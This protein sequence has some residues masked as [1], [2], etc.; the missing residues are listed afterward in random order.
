MLIEKGRCSSWLN[1]AQRLLILLILSFITL[2][3]FMMIHENNFNQLTQAVY[4]VIEGKPHWLAYQ[5]RLLGPY[6][7]LAISKVGFSFY[8]SLKI[9]YWITITAEI[10]LL[11]FVL[12]P[13]TATEK[14]A[15][16]LVALY[17]LAFTLYQ[18]SWYY[19][20]DSMDVIIFTLFSYL[21][22]KNSKTISMV[23]LFLISLLNRES[24]L[25]IAFYFIVQGLDVKFE[26]KNLKINIIS[27]KR[28]VLGL[29]MMIFGIIE[30][31]FVRTLLFISKPNGLYDLK[32]KTLGNF[33]NLPQNFVNFDIR[34]WFF[35]YGSLSVLF[36]I[37]K[38]FNKNQN[39]LFLT[40]I[41]MM[42]GI[43]VFGLIDETRLYLML[44]PIFIF[45]SINFQSNKFHVELGLRT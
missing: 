24:A 35:I 42:I 30:I 44:F 45:L 1:Q 41:A 3:F 33:I 23:T 12:R 15:Y 31:K 4:G 13:F 10:L 26:K 14:A 32:H 36:M 29:G 25:F 43:L 11:F 38:S 21:V 2:Y 7:V 20:W 39:D 22:L 6:M 37:Y 9:Y 5:N 18:H 40:Y 19:A 34:G 28:I 16:A 17:C 8:N 27:L